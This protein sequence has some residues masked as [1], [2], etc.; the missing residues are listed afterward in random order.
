MQSSSYFAL[1]WLLRP[2]LFP[3]PPRWR[4]VFANPSPSPLPVSG[5]VAH[6]PMSWAGHSTIKHFFGCVKTFRGWMPGFRTLPGIE[7][8]VLK[9]PR[10]WVS[11]FEKLPGVKSPVLENFQG[12]GTAIFKNECTQGS[13]VSLKTMQNSDSA[14]FI[15]E[16]CEF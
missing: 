3:A 10:G 7:C 14:F 12:L 8:P 9:V 5:H 13:G 16:Y 1:C 2:G 11:G 6:H 4:R 15:P